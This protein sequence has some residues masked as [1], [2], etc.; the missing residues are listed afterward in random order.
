MNRSTAAAVAVA[1]VLGVVG[2]TYLGTVTGDGDGT[3]GSRR[4][5]TEDPKSS[6]T[7]PT[8]ASSTPG[9][10]LTPAQL[11]YMD[12]R[13]IHDGYTHVDVTGIDLATVDS[14]VR[15]RGGWL[16]VERTGDE[17]SAYR[18]TVVSLGGDQS[19][20]GEFSGLWDISEDGDLFVAWRGEEYAVTDLTDGTDLELSIQ[21]P[22]RSE[23]VANAAFVGS[24]VLTGWA[25]AHGESWTLRTDLASSRTRRVET[26]GLEDWLASPRGLLLT[27]SESINDIAC[28]AGGAV[29]D[30]E[31][32]WWRTCDWLYSGLRP[33]FSPNGEQLLAVPVTTEGFGP[34]AFG[35]LNSETGD[36]I[37][38]HDA[39]DWAVAAEWGDNNEF[40]VLAQKSAD[41]TDGLIYRCRVG[42]SCQRERESSVRLVLGTGV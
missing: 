25:T 4:E 16:V 29:R 12:A 2:G 7:G 18:G 11:L 1:A 13:T 38:E 20:L 19:D 5:P 9:A 39:P 31:G 36:E 3:Q 35:V 17:E 28:V 22:P 26:S 37:A 8:T 27:G 40:F 21:P 15:I 34:S 33:S 10:P 32:T 42:E 24:A 6:G 41:N 23:S 14:L 30:L